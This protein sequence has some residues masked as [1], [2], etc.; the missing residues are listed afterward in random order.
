MEL[1]FGGAGI[2]VTK[3]IDNELCV[4]IGKR[5]DGQ[6]WAIPA[7]KRKV[8]DGILKFTAIRELNEEFGFCVC[9]IST[10]EISATNIFGEDRNH[11]LISVLNHIHREI[12]YYL[13]WLYLL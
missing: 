9:D 6:G 7:G 4:L 1:F 3:K 13:F 8:S 11:K 2:I 10:G 5:S 12:H